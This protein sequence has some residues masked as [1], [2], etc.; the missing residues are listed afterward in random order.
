MGTIEAGKIHVPFI[1]TYGATS[2]DDAPYP[3]TR[4]DPDGPIRK[5][6]NAQLADPTSKI[7]RAGKHAVVT[8]DSVRPHHK[9][10]SVVH[11]L[12]EVKDG[13]MQDWNNPISWEQL[14]EDSDFL[15]AFQE[16]VFKEVDTGKPYYAQFGWTPFNNN[17]EMWFTK[18]GG[19]T[20]KRAHWHS[21]PPFDQQ[22]IDGYITPDQKLS[23]TD[24]RFLSLFFDIGAQLAKEHISQVKDVS[25]HIHQWTVMDGL[26]QRT[27]YGFYSIQDALSQL[28]KFH[29]SLKDDWNMWAKKLYKE[30]AGDFTVDFDGIEKSLLLFSPIVGGSLFVPTNDEKELIGMDVQ[31]P[32]RVWVSL[33]SPIMKPLLVNGVQVFR[34]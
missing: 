28:Y 30:Y 12:P 2:G 8:L 34:D 19:M 33:L 3:P 7:L 25:S 18:Q 26:I 6:I 17:P 22:K 24:I 1:R 10:G 21:T 16:D 27:A 4:Q 14:I 29:M 5:K 11:W 31:H 15:S 13:Q 9:K 23:E 32:C 20:I